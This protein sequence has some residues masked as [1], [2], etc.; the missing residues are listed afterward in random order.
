MASLFDDGH[1]EERRDAAIQNLAV[2]PALLDRHARC[3]TSR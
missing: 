2:L 3:V 1:C